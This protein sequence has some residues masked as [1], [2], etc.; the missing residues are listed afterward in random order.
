M[1]NILSCQPGSI[2]T[3]KE[4]NGFFFN[5][6]ENKTSKANLAKKYLKHF[7]FRDNRKYE[8]YCGVMRDKGP[9]CIMFFRVEEEG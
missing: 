5:A 7:S 1:R 8:L 3:G 2:F 6:L 4:I 9:E